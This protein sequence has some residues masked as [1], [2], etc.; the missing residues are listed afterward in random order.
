[1]ISIP[2]GYLFLPHMTK[3]SVFFLSQDSFDSPV[4][5]FVWLG[6]FAYYSLFK[7]NKLLIMTLY[8]TITWCFDLKES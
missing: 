4:S 2:C 5:L 7:Q 1:M 8:S 3:Q 6:F